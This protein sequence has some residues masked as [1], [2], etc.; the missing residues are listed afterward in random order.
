MTSQY[1]KG[2][3]TKATNLPH[4][5]IDEYKSLIQGTSQSNGACCLKALALFSSKLEE[6]HA[7]YS[8]SFTPSNNG[9]ETSFDKE[10]QEVLALLG[11]AMQWQ[12]NPECHVPNATSQPITQQES[13]LKI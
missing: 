5:E 4:A 6:A 13:P 1:Y 12:L 3:G 11:E 9:E 7:K 8:T 2:A 10:Q